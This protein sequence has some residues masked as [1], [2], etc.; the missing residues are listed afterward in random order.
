MALFPRTWAD[1]NRH[2]QALDPEMFLEALPGH[3]Q[4][5]SA[6]VQAGFGVIPKL[7]AHG[8]PIYSHRLS[9]EQAATRIEQAHAPYHKELTRRLSLAKQRFGFAVLVDCHSM[10]R[11]GRQMEPPHGV[12]EIVLGDRYGASCNLSLRNCLDTAFTKQGFSVSHNQPYAGGYSIRRYGRPRLNLHAIQIE[13]AR[14]LY[15]DESTL[16]A[17]E[18]F[19]DIAGQMT[20]IMRELKKFV[21]QFARELKA[22]ETVSF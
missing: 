3:E 20:Q 7:A 9:R 16:K 18:H 1:A 4:Q 21:R 19:S 13:I 8:Y 11:A 2:P 5:L 6:Q 17:H 15:M 10:P 12:T 22:D 14:D